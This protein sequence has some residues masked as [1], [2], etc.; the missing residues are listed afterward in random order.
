MCVCVCVSMCCDRAGTLPVM[1]LLLVLLFVALKFQAPLPDSRPAAQQVPAAD[2]LMVCSFALFL[3]HGH[4][5]VWAISFWFSLS[6]CILSIMEVYLGQRKCLEVWTYCTHGSPFPFALIFIIENLLK[7][8]FS[9]LRKSSTL[10]IMKY[11]LDDKI[12]YN[13]VSKP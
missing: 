12:Y 7:Y 3:S 8:F 13:E 10:R 6:F 11:F 4:N 2:P 5:C 9:C 1:R